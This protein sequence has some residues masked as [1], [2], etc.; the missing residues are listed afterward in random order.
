MSTLTVEHVARIEGHGTISVDV[1]ALRVVSEG[2]TLTT[3]AFEAGF[4]S[5]AHLSST[6]RA[7][8]GLT[9]S[10]LISLGSSIEFS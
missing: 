1:D 9:L 3:A 4:S 2:E 7:M 6:F 10:S 8:F 5:S